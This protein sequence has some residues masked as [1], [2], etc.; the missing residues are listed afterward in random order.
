MMDG[1]F[2]DT[3]NKQ[4]IIING[5]YNIQTKKQ[6]TKNTQCVLQRDNDIFPE[7]EEYTSWMVGT[8]Y[9]GLL[10]Y[11]NQLQINPMKLDDIEEWPTPTT[12][13]EVKLFLG[14]G[15]FDQEFTQN[16]EDLT[17][18]QNK[19]NENEQDNNDMVILPDGSFLDLL[20]HEFDN[21]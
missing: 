1:I 4:W 10:N 14:F 2:Q 9:E 12:M 18:P 19:R 17:K 20:D 6:D 16:N 5:N 8:K 13:K 7:P 21:E 3:K 11:E 15:N